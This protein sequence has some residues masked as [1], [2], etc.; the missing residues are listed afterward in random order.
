MI[1]LDTNVVSAL[2][3]QDLTSPVHQWLATQ[4]P[5]RIWITSITV[6]EVW[7]GIC[8]MPLGRRRHAIEAGFESIIANRLADRV[9]SFDHQ[10]AI[11]TA[12]LSARRYREGRPVDLADT[13]ISGVVISRRATLATRNS[14]H[15]SDIGRPVIDPWTG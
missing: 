15:Y 6:M 7:A 2:M 14:S 8:Q 5:S 13:Q 12:E 10:A 4:R 3:T 1:V 11:A 9:L